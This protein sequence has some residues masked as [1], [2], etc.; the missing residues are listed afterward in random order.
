[1]PKAN[2]PGQSGHFI[3]KA[4]QENNQASNVLHKFKYFHHR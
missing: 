4:T 2:A 3:K 1:M